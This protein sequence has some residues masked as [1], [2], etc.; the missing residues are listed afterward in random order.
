MLTNRI[1]TAPGRL[2]WM[3]TAA[4]VLALVA[5]AAELH[6]RL[7]GEHAVRCLDDVGESVV[8]LSAAAACFVGARRHPSMRTFWIMLAIATGGW[9]IGESIWSYY[10]LLGRHQTPFPSLADAGF[11]IYPVA[12]ALALWAFPANANRVARGRWFLDAAIVTAALVTVS[13]PTALGAAVHGTGESRLALWVSLAYPLGDIL[14]LTLALTSLGLARRHRRE[15]TVVAAA[16]AAMAISDSAFSYLTALGRYHTGGLIDLGWVASFLLLVPLP[17]WVDSGE[18]VE[19]GPVDD[20]RGATVSQL[21]YVPLLVA[22][23][24]MTYQR[25]QHLSIAGVEVCSA[26]VT[27]LLVLFR[28]YLTVRENRLLLDALALREAQLATQAFHDE[29]TGLANRALFMNRVEHAIDLHARDLRG[30]AV[31]FCDLDDFK[32]VNDTLGHAA[33]DQLLIQVADR[34]RAAL[35]PGDTLSRLGGDEFAV[36][37]EDSSAPRSAAARL[38][39]VM[40]QPFQLAQ[41]TVAVRISVGVAELPP[42][43]GAITTDELLARADIAMYSAKRSGKGKLACYDPAMVVPHADDLH[44]RQP[45]ELAVRE[46]TLTLAFQPLVYLETGQLLGFEAL[47]RW[48][49]AGRSVPPDQFIPIAQ[50][51]G[52]MPALTDLVLEEACRQ[53]AEWSAAL[54]HRRLRVGVNV[55]PAL[56][57]DAQLPDRVAACVQRYDLE[58]DQLVLEIT[59]EA[60][61]EDPEAAA[62][63]AHRLRGLG[64]RISLD[65][66]GRGYSSLVHLQRIPLQSLKIDRAF[67]RNVDT[68]P[69]AARFAGALIRLATDLGLDVV[70][71]GIERS[72]QADVLRAAGGRF[73]QGY[74]YGRPLPATEIPIRDLTGLIRT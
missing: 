16:M 39:E 37:L 3:L 62:S 43:A 19:S 46:H 51:A 71:E 72:E 32:A 23:V 56:F 22:A 55:P 70:A 15:L 17:F 45:L 44:L 64:V 2:A 41:N 50:R 21:P 63:V 47:A 14:I 34:L 9:G 7:G 8:A 26:V 38:V 20:R 52:L 69:S 59:E 66:F 40:T 33:G 30:L 12:G 27:A 60:L 42:L 49:H 24:L 18:R 29:L 54:G 65:D 6:L 4:C 67:I 35:R 11:L 31:L 28:Q 58:T 5:L 1:G 74:L 48:Q 10:E 61:I 73:G 53:L 36:L 25:W 68:E 57:T 13:W